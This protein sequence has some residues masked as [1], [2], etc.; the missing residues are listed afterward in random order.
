MSIYRAY[1]IRGVYPKELN[2]KIAEQVGRAFGTLN[3]GK[4]AIGSDCRLS[5]PALKESVI[6]GLKSSGSSAIDLG[7]ITTPMLIFAVGSYGYDGG[8]M[9]TASHNPK[10]YNGIKMYSKGAKPL[11]YEAGISKV[12][13]L[14]KKKIFRKGSGRCTKRNI[15]DDYVQALLS[16]VSFARRNL[17]IVVDAGNGS[18]SWI[19]P[20]ILKSA[21]FEVTKMFCEFD[22]RF[23]NHHPD[24]DNEANMEDLKKKVLEVQADIG[25][26][27]DGDGDRVGVIDN[28]GRRVGTNK[29]FCMLIEDLLAGK[30]GAKIVYDIL[31]SETVPEKVRELGGEPLVS[32]VG[33]SFIAEKM[34]AEDAELGGELS[35]HYYF[36]ELYCGDDAAFASLRL[37]E[38]LAKKQEKLSELADRMPSYFYGSF[39][40][41]CPD[42]KKAEKVQAVKAKYET[43]GKKTVCIDGVK[44][45]FEDGWML[46]RPSNTAPQIVCGWESKTKEGFDRIEKIVREESKM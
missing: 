25:L 37:I 12:E 35:G 21:G 42:E 27:Y 5:S 13:E 15:E 29:T 16:R 30:P 31:S 33:H 23:P 3:P 39:R 28:L 34:I 22:G 6:A 44:V 1:D 2:E 18:A 40:V 10:E 11:T 26:A 7:I 45:F 20:R 4:I 14:V 36:K 8:I 17:K 32:M 46:L 9:I 43:E 19:V 24:P 38:L 41:E